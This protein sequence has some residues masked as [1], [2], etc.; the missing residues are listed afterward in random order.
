MTLTGRGDPRPGSVGLASRAVQLGHVTAQELVGRALDRIQLDNPTLNAVVEVDADGAMKAAWE[1]D[2]QAHKGVL[3]GVPLLVKDTENA[4]GFRTTF[5]STHFSHGPP[6]AADSPTVSAWKKCGAVVIGKT[7]TSEFGWEG[8]SYNR[9]YG[10]TR[11]P[12]LLE[13]SP[14]G[15]SGGSAAALAAGFAGMATASDAGGSTRTP[16]A[17]CGLLGLKPTNGLLSFDQQPGGIDQLTPGVLATRP[18]DLRL[19][20][21]TLGRSPARNPADSSL[22]TGIEFR[23]RVV[24]DGVLDT[25]VNSKAE[26]WAEELQDFA[27]AIG[28]RSRI[29]PEPVFFDTTPDRDALVN[30]ALDT[31]NFLGWD[32]LRSH[33][34]RID[35]SLAAA[36]DEFGS[37]TLDD[38]LSLR[39]RRKQYVEALDSAIGTGLLVTPTLNIPGL[40]VSGRLVNAQSD[41]STALE[42]S[43]TNTN[44]QNWTGHPALS[45][46]AGLLSSGAPFGLQFTARKGDDGVL[47]E[48]AERWFDAYPWPEVAP[49]YQS[50]WTTEYG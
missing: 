48:L 24:G 38:Y 5:G 19:L 22:P 26:Y 34:E 28:V 6:A 49:R 36:F 21:E 46:P 43:L 10:G 13:R 39:R 25:E 9:L 8:H 44:V 4:A 50:L 47:L 3:A 16:A 14:G 7:N 33:K 23:Y 35:P 17:Q 40:L 15:S 30:F 2:R 20:F 32:W 18:G 37:F 12:W 27:H 45:V 29:R 42:Q 41:Q 11:N 31:F 1:V